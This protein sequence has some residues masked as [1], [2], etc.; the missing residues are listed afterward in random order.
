MAEFE[1]A[2]KIVLKHEGGFQIDPNDDGNWTG[3]IKGRGELKG[4]NH[5]ISAAS[6]PAEN[7]KTLTEDRAKEIYLRDYW[8][9]GQYQSLKSQDVAN[10][11]LDLS[12][13]MQGKGSIGSAIRLLQKAINALYMDGQAPV[14]VDGS[15]GAST[16]TAANAL[17]AADLLAA[18]KDQA[19]GHYRQIAE[20][21]PRKAVYLKGWEKRVLA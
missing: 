17:D 19:V 11:L 21:Y 8:L 16:Q 14:I 18:L 13:T 12:V 7:I 15:W 10:K 9:D 3:G 5:G 6:Y 20:M 2:V 4:T 1:P